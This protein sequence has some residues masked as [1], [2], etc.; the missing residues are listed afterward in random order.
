[1]GNGLNNICQVLLENPYFLHFFLF[2]ISMSFR[3]QAPEISNIR[4][5]QAGNIVNLLYDLAGAR[6]IL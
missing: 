2:L 1:M 5:I 3:T 4:I 6:S